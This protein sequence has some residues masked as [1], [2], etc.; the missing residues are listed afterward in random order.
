M[1]SWVSPL[2]VGTVR[3][4]DDWSLHYSTCV[5]VYIHDPSVLLSQNI[6]QAARE[7]WWMACFVLVNRL[8]CE[9]RTNYAFVGQNLTRV[10]IRAVIRYNSPTP[11]VLKLRRHGCGLRQPFLVGCLRDT[12]AFEAVKEEPS[13][14]DPLP[15]ET[16]SEVKREPADPG[17]SRSSSP[18]TGMYQPTDRVGIQTYLH[19]YNIQ[20]WP[21]PVLHRLLDSGFAT[22]ALSL[23]LKKKPWRFVRYADG[24]GV[25]EVAYGEWC[26]L[27]CENRSRSKNW[28]SFRYRVSSFTKINRF[29]NTV[30]GKNW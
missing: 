12:G 14:Q 6:Q 2:K 25:S 29:W 15:I 9:I 19:T 7:Q 1:L 22:S 23:R 18:N 8:C 30:C 28:E 27:K 17:N 20:T 3:F 11:G 13:V 5:H 21:E 10:T 26:V 4:R 24:D 16:P